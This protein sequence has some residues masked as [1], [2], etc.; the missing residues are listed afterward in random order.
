MVM[1]VQ[2][3]QSKTELLEGFQEPH[4]RETTSHVW[5]ESYNKPNQRNICHWWNTGEDSSSNHQ[6]AY[7]LSCIRKLQ[8][9]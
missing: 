5:G 4:L 1:S 6:T 9:V 7:I 8:N 2:T 3:K